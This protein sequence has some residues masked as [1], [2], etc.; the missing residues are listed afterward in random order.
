MDTPWVA[1]A[2]TAMIEKSRDVVGAVAVL[3]QDGLQLL[4]AKGRNQLIKQMRT[5]LHQWFDAVVLPEN[6]CCRQDTDDYTGE[7]RKASVSATV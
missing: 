2:F 7:S 5:A 1:D 3:S 4:E 6:G